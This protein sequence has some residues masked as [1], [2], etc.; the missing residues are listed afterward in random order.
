MKSF[1]AGLPA[2]WKKYASHNIL[3]LLYVG[4][5][6]INSFILRV[7]TVKFT[8]NFVKPILADIAA[9]LII[10]M[11]GYLI[12]PKRRIVYYM[13]FTSVNSLLCVINSI[14]YTNYKSFASV[15]L[16]STAS[17]LGGV[18]DA[19]TKNIMEA[20]D[21]IFLWAI[22]AM[23]AVYV[24]IRKK[25][26]GYFDEIAKEKKG[27]RQFLS[28]FLTGLAFAAVAAVMFTGTDYSRLRK[29]W[30]REYT[31][32]TFGLYTYQISDTIQSV[33]SKVSLMFGYDESKAQFTDFY[34]DKD[35]KDAVSRENEYSDLFKGK[36]MLVIHCESMQNFML[37][38]Y[39]NGEEV[40]PTL[41]KLAREGIYFSNFYAQESVGTSSDSEFTFSTSLM[42]AS[43][44]TVAI[45]YWDRDY[46]S[47][48][49]LVKEKGYFVFSMHGNNGSYWNR[50]NL[51]NSLGYDKFFNYSTDFDIDETIGLGL[52]DKSFFRQAVPKIKE[53]DSENKNWYGAMIM[54]T[55][56]TPFT[57]IERV[58]D[59]AVDFKYK[60]KND[61]TGLYE[62]ISA[63]FLE[64]TKLGSYFKSV[65]YAD[66]ALAQ[67][68]QD[69]DNEGLLDDTVVIL[70]G[71]HDA[72]VKEEEYSYYYNYDPFNDTALEEDDPGYVPVDDFYYNINRKV[73]FII[74]SKD[75]GYEPKEITKVMGMYDVLPTLGNLFGFKDQY[76]LGHD[77]L[78]IDEG[79]EN[80]VIFP[81][82]NFVT[83]SIYY[84]SQKDIYF[85]LAGY[86]NIAMNVPCNQV[87]KDTPIPLYDEAKEGIFKT[88]PDENY[89]QEAADARKDDG[90]VD[91]SYI[92]AYSDYAEQRISISNSI[93]YYDMINKTEDGFGDLEEIDETPSI[94][95]DDGY[96]V[97]APPS[98]HKNK[99][100][101]AA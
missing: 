14:Y 89:S 42:P 56:H 78:S 43:T 8:Y 45:N 70:Y 77:V 48:Q 95:A 83:D 100:I 53:I 81:N 7:F 93:I 4:S 99:Q 38:S 12:K 85:D 19:V 16:I 27:R 47:I 15:S 62:E 5:S 61:V 2:K 25:K 80:V 39:M 57:D 71:D 13:I 35:T 90:C 41:N 76:A 6:L 74:W 18:M 72:K 97:F 36:N 52:S 98:Y 65:H 3:F 54:L 11:F 84:D 30:N 87:Y 31:L 60:K 17:Q 101:A 75:G 88:L 55:N 68:L 59:F 82:G 40:T 50:M 24:V 69:M 66:E 23:I 37:G 29:Q 92:Q 22:I 34:T 64:G 20:K 49:K 63:P 32:A 91:E 58:S 10:G 33:Y 26:P 46:T 79:M 94:S 21:L 28:T 9:V 67:L 1:F 51:H 73:P 44:G 96:S 86:E